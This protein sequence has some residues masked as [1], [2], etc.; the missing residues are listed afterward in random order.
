MTVEVGDQPPHPEDLVS[1]QDLGGIREI[2]GLQANAGRI[3]EN[4][5]ED[6]LLR[7]S[8]YEDEVLAPDLLLA[9]KDD[10]VPLPEGGAGLPLH[11]FSDNI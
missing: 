7:L 2:E 11:R 6:G 5:P 3:E 8:V 1:M 9:G 4:L 10:D